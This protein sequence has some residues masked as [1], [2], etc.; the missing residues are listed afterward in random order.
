MQEDKSSQKDQRQ[1]PNSQVQQE[2]ARALKQGSSILNFIIKAVGLFIIVFF[3][4]N[5]LKSEFLRLLD[6]LK[7]KYKN[8]K[9]VINRLINKLGK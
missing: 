1:Q 6:Y 2:Q 4:Y 7:I 3:I 9:D 8:Y 5:T